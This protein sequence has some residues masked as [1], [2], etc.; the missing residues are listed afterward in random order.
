MNFS[1]FLI[2][3]HSD[4]DV[5]FVFL[6]GE[7]WNYYGSMK[8]SEMITEGRFPH[9]VDRTS[10]KHHL[11]PIE[12]E[13]IDLMINV[14]QLGCQHGKTYILHDKPHPFLD[15]FKYRLI[16]ERSSTHSAACR[17]VSSPLTVEYH[18]TDHLHLFTDFRAVNASALAML[19]NAHE[20]MN[21]FFNSYHDTLD[22]LNNGTSVLDH[23]YLI[24]QVI[25][26]YV[27]FRPCPDGWMKEQ[28]SDRI[29]SLFDCFLR[30]N[31]SRLIVETNE[32]DAW[33]FHEVSDR[34]RRHFSFLQ[35]IL[36]PSDVKAYL[37]EHFLDASSYIHD[38]LL[39]WIAE[40]TRNATQA[41]CDELADLVPARIYQSSTKTC[42]RVSINS[43][44]LL[45]NQDEDVDERFLFV[46]NQD[47][48]ELLVYM[49]ADT[50]RDY[51]MLACGIVLCL[52]GLVSSYFLVH[53]SPIF[54]IWTAKIRLHRAELQ[55]HCL[56]QVEKGA[57][58]EWVHLFI[59]C[60]KL[61]SL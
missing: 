48:P 61:T 42:L 8:L 22:H 36:H 51:L 55:L 25:C 31:C 17:H 38:I 5:L 11:H 4:K 30:S 26:D 59:I 52:C 2:S 14:D 15:K 1:R 20:K 7:N 46:S 34:M 29:Q 16:G 10:N 28:L 49:T 23:I 32:T 39:N 35:P 44:N 24:L 19:T 18:Q 13:H 56:S 43:I 9:R 21:P 54:L 3:G 41:A 60:T 33:Y 57:I 53:L 40:R 27:N 45:R 37:E 58:V 12:P 47:E 6:N 50:K